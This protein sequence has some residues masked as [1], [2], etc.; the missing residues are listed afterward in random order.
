[1]FSCASEDTEV[2]RLAT[3]PANPDF[4]ALFRRLPSP[5]MVLDR[6]FNYVDANEAYCQV[7]ERRRD[8]LIGRNLFDLFP[9]PGDSGRRLRESF[10]RVVETGQPDSIPLLPYPIPL[11]LSRGGGMEMRYWSAAH[12]P[13]LDAHGH[14][15][16][17]VQNTVDVTELQQLKA[18]AYGP[19]GDEV[20]P[21]ARDL[22]QRTRDVERA[23]RLLLEET[24]GLRDLFMQAPGF[25]AVLSG[26][27]LVFSLV[28]KTYQQL[29]GHR[30]VIGRTLLEALPEVRD[31]RFGDL[32]RGVMRTGEP[33]IGSAASVMLQRQPGARL[34]ERFVDFIYQP[35]RAADGHVWGV[36]VEGSDVTDR[37]TA[38]RQQKLLLDELNHR[39][40]NTLA[41]V[42]AIASQT[43]RTNAEP[44]AF[45][46]A[47]ESRLIALSA[48]H[49]LLT[50]T[51]WRSAALRDVLLLEL[52]PF[53]PERY[54]LEGPE[55]SLS[56]T[57]ALTLGL[58]FHEL[59]TNAAK[60]GALSAPDGRVDVAWGLAPAAEGLRLEL[61]WIER[62]GPKVSP[63]TRRGFGSRL[64]E[65]SLTGQMRGKALLDFAVD[66]LRCRILLPL[67]G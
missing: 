16:F 2:A 5:Y 26:P 21:A 20:A 56:P 51:N 25:M 41:T 13:L 6:S 7:T 47:F 57:E 42:Q 61:D 40:K 52:K 27:D 60:Y 39:V 11:P 44:A 9:N 65:R 67:Q 45:R 24:Q 59:A 1:L 53:G 17:V 43:L 8:E 33:F 36:F 50:A 14:T 23:N 37:V 19:S 63:P 64:I 38:E 46:E 54:S 31:Q 32:L 62:G 49:D 3:P 10:E 34:E 4:E 15:A 28:N 35:I 55:A 18:I 29:I 30:P 12:V 48:T 58:L 22:L 66:G